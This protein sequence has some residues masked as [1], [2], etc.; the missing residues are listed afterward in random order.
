MFLL[1]SKSETR[2]NEQ[3]G[4]FLPAEFNNYY[5]CNPDHCNDRLSQ[6]PFEQS[7]IEG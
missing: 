4:N 6:L 1:Y 2:Q 7:D 5:G 3:Q